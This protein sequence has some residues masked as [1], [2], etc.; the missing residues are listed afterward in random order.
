MANIAYEVVAEFVMNE[1]AAVLATNK[2][3]GAIDSLAQKTDQAIFGA[4]R[5]G[6]AYAVNFLT[7][8]GGVLGLLGSA[9][10]SSQK[11]RS[12]QIELANTMVQNGFKIGGQM[13]SF[14]DSLYIADG[15]MGE[16][17][18]KGNKFVISPTAL[19]ESTKLFGA[20]LAPKGLAGQNMENAIE[21]SRVAIKGTPALGIDE[22]QAR[23]GIFSAL[24]GQLQKGSGF[25]RILLEAGDVIKK[26]SN[27]AITDVK[28]FNKA[29]AGLRLKALIAGLDKLAGSSAAVNARGS[30]LINKLMFIKEQFIGIGSVLK[31]FGDTLSRILGPVLDKISY[32]I[33]TK[34]RFGIEIIDRAV[35]RM[36]GSA[37]QLYITANNIAMASKDIEKAKTASNIFIMVSALS[38]LFKILGGSGSSVIT[39]ALSSLGPI[40]TGIGKAI[41]FVGSILLRG[42]VIKFFQLVGG[43]VLKATGIFASFLFIFRVLTEAGAKFRIGLLKVIE[44]ISG[45]FL[46]QMDRFLNAIGLMV[47]PF[48][49]VVD[50]FSD[51][52][53]ESSILYEAVKLIPPAFSLL[54]DALEGFA[55]GVQSVFIFLKSAGAF[56]GGFFGTLSNAFTDPSKLLSG[57]FLKSIFT[58][59]FEA[60]NDEMNSGVDK[61]VNSLLN[62]SGKVEKV[63]KN[64]M[65]VK[66]DNTFNIREKI[67]P[68]R[69][70]FTMKDQ[71]DKLARNRKSA[72]GKP[73]LSGGAF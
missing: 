14:N 50:V 25:E 53:A 43:A 1:T 29:S 23:T 2:I 9:I 12:T 3:T 66:I 64:N 58:N 16:I 30:L 45:P 32:I 19:A 27:G 18:K 13:A 24:A 35:G 56:L 52:I 28:S 38:G 40:F 67:E 17:I 70:A 36:G 20:I 37:E 73:L 5:L 22:N 68:D 34:L 48:D 33:S 54:N 59:S 42:G 46:K 31:P 69:I 71:L 60:F 41:A 11:F 51:F 39:G 7:G 49:F 57:D 6:K 8:G 72:V 62:P 26:V 65:E 21:L 63:A 44:E 4:F 47:E 55:I 61:V 10:T 15:I